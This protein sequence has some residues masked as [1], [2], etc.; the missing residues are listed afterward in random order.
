MSEK[1]KTPGGATASDRSGLTSGLATDIHRGMVSLPTHTQPFRAGRWQQWLPGAGFIVVTTVLAHVLFSRFGLNPTDD[2]FVLA[3]ARRILAGEVPHLDF[4]SIRPAGSFFLHAPFVL[5]GSERTFMLSRLFVWFQFA[6]IAWAW[7]SIIRHRF[8]ALSNWLEQVAA[9]FVVFVFCSHSFPVMAWHSLDG[10]WAASLGSVLCDSGSGRR[11]TAGYILVGLAP[12]FRQG[13]VFFVPL[14]LLLFGDVRRWRCWLAALMP[15]AFYLAYLTANGALGDS[16]RQLA[17][18][19]GSDTWRAGVVSYFSRLESLWGLLLGFIGCRLVHDRLPGA[20]IR[21]GMQVAGSLLL[22]SVPGIIAFRLGGADYLFRTCL[23]LFGIAFGAT[24]ALALADLSISARVRAALLGLAVAWSVSLSL[25]YNTPA[26]A[27]GVLVLIMMAGARGIA[28][29]RGLVSATRGMRV[30][31]RVA[32]I[33][34]LAATM[35]G[36]VLVRRNHVYWEPNA[37][38]LVVDLG[39]ALRGAQGIRTDGHIAAVWQDLRLVEDSLRAVGRQ[40][41]V[42]PEFAADWVKNPQRNPLPSD[43]PLD[44]EMGPDARRVAKAIADRRGRLVVILQ[45]FEARYLPW[46]LDPLWAGRPVV[47]YV[48]RELDWT[49]ETEF[50]NLYE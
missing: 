21:L 23:F 8:A 4:I 34:L 38:E 30:V 20:R 7:V 45:K 29:E 37:Q 48:E 47:E 2:G 1:V 22:Y 5:L 19:A 35:V 6:C 17:S 9:G 11:K 46:R 26:L 24:A 12:L 41:C 18:H 10:L 3:G 31:E 13:F 39:G 43:W 14:S 36:F 25:G 27:S 16:V 50:F 42:V 40:Y 49:G 33:L 28:G 32:L 15:I 44:V